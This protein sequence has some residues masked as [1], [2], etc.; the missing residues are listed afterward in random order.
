[1]QDIISRAKI[2]AKDTWTEAVQNWEGRNQDHNYRDILAR[3]NIKAALKTLELKTEGKFLDI[4]CAEGVETFYIRDVLSKL[5]NSGV[6]YGYDPQKDFIKTARKLNT[7]NS[8]IP[9]QFGNGSIRQFLEKYKL[10]KNVDLVTS[11][12]VLQDLPDIHKYLDNVNQALNKNGTGIFLFVNP[13][14]AEAMKNKDAMKINENLNPKDINVPWRFAGKYP[15]VEEKGETFFVPYFQRTINDY[16]KY[17]QKHFKQVNFIGL[18]PSNKDILKSEKE[19]KSPFYN[20]KGNVYHPEITE[21]DSSL[22][23]IAKK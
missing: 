7:Y 6:M 9:I 15:I 5:G 23:I 1:M 17:F 20:H 2:W 3:P 22:I 12:F 16:R 19:H 4:G 18:K 21:M 8:S 11:I 10:S 13:K 14:F